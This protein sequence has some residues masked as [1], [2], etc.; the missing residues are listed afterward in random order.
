MCER[1]GVAA[2]FPPRGP[3]VEVTMPEE[4]RRAL[5]LRCR[6]GRTPLLRAAQHPWELG[7]FYPPG[8]F[9]WAQE[10]LGNRQVI[11]M[12]GRC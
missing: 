6:A 12:C 2:L 10:A 11:L 8:R 5:D 1:E 7:Q 4:M 9:Q 3:V